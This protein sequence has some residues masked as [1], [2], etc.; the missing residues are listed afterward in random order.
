MLLYAFL[1]SPAH[2][3]M[4]HRPSSGGWQKGECSLQRLLQ[5]IHLKSLRR[6]SPRPPGPPSQAGFLQRRRAVPFG[7]RLS[8]FTFLFSR[9]SLVLPSVISQKNIINSLLLKQN[10]RVL[11]YMGLW[12]HRERSWRVV[13]SLGLCACPRPG[14]AW[15]EPSMETT[16]DSWRP[17]SSLTQVSQLK[18]IV[19]CIS[20]HLGDLRLRRCL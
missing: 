15:Q 5:D 2:Y 13:M 8:F 16:R 11:S 7:E 4:L 14:Q 18:W 3:F 1:A 9:I 19:S 6:V 20:P 10:L 12:V 17:T